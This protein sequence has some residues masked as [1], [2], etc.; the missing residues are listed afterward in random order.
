MTKQQLIEAY[1]STLINPN[2]KRMISRNFGKA[3][4]AENYQKAME[5]KSVCRQEPCSMT[6]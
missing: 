1:E 5:D 6:H 4:R 3:H 2:R